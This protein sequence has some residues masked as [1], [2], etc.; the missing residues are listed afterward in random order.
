MSL[1]GPPP[2]IPAALAAATTGTDPVTGTPTIVGILDARGPD[3]LTNSISDV[4]HAASG[5]GNII[6]GRV[7]E[8]RPDGTVF[9][10]APSGAEL[11]FRHPPEVPIEVGSTITLRLVAIVPA[12][13]AVLL[14][15][16]GRSVSGLLA[17]AGNAA[18]QAA[19]DG[20]PT[21][22]ALPNPAGSPVPIPARQGSPADLGFGVASALV[23]T[24]G[25]E[26]D[27]GPVV[28]PG[29]T[30][31][32]LSARAALTAATETADATAAGPPVVAVLVRTAPPRPG[33]SA[34]VLGTRYLLSVMAV[35]PPS[36]ESTPPALAST[37]APTSRPI[38][39]EPPLATADP[40]TAAAAPIIPLAGTTPRPITSTPPVLPTGQPAGAESVP[41]APVS[42]PAPAAPDL[43][44]F[45]PQAA[46]LA[47]RV[48][49][50]RSATD[51]L[52]ETA[53]G[54]LALP[55]G[56]DQ[57]AIGSAVHL[58]VVA[59]ARPLPTTPTSPVTDPAAA[60]SGATSSVDAMATVPPT[61]LQQALAVLATLQPDLA[62]AA[63][64]AFVLQPGARL[65]A[66]I[67]G[68][69][70]GVHSGAPKRWSESPARAALDALDHGAL[71]EALDGDAAAIG[72]QTLPA[73][74]AD[75]KVTV[76]PYLGVE[77]QQPARLYQRLAE[78]KIEGDGSATS[79]A[80]Q[81]FVVEIELHRLGPLQFD[82]L[83]RERR[84][85]LAVR[86]TQALE[87]ELQ[88]EIGHIFRETIGISGY[89]GDL[90]FG[91]LG[92]FP[93]LQTLSQTGAHE[94]SA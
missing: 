15:V 52:V 71:R 1:T 32:A 18:R 75:W 64:D 50:P 29:S 86:T 17:R 60:L 33:V 47:G 35:A 26:T 89:A 48:V 37:P 70:A 76:L 20:P 27:S 55:Q 58:R 81:R 73:D 10:T 82:G 11:S 79:A 66:L 45:T 40:V 9:L 22:T 72:S 14:A 53:V 46:L 28:V 6:T 80:G 16:D 78:A 12:P 69:L 85:D 77:S 23:A 59:V 87:A 93:L 94:I 7:A 67:F 83:V 24:L 25:R 88:A 19:A 5:P 8:I 63:T 68:F 61:A 41:I 91:R 92:R 43:T 84:F 21:A 54:T 30:G 13:Q 49:A 39:P 74:P 3:R 56:E 38:A 2:P 65:A 42:S 44:T 57:I 51:T 62:K 90:V 31:A 36:G 34:P 4:L